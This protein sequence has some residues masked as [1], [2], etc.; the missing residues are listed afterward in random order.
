M[1]GKTVEKDEKGGEGESQS[2][3]SLMPFLFE[4]PNLY[5]QMHQP[6]VHTLQTFVAA[7][8]A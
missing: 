1:E 2:P 4:T 6:H 3:L 7:L 8:Q 5:E